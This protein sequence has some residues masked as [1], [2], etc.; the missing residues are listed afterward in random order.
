MVTKELFDVKHTLEQRIAILDL[1]VCYKV[2]LNLFLF[3]SPCPCFLHKGTQ[4]FLFYVVYFRP[5][6]VTIL[7]TA[8]PPPPFVASVAVQNAEMSERLKAYQELE[9]AADTDAA[10]VVRALNV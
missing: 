4:V 2:M 9:R 5:P 6:C 1:K 8:L 7:L 3:F 10:V